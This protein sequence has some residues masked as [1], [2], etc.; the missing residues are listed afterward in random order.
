MRGLS[1][2]DSMLWWQPMHLS[3]RGI[4]ETALRLR[5]GVAV[6]AVD[7]HFLHMDVV[8]KLD[9]LGDH[10]PQRVIAVGCLAADRSALL[11]RLVRL[12]GRR[13]SSVWCAG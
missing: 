4:P 9:G 8:R 12:K 7:S 1:L 13:M 6:Q 5:I 11:E 2:T 10:G 3:R